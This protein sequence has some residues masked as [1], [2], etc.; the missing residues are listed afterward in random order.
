MLNAQENEDFIAC[1]LG[2]SDSL[3]DS[4]SW[5]P[6]ASDSGISEDPNSDQLDSPPHYVP[7]GSPGAY[8]DGGHSELA[9]TSYQDPCQAMSVL[10]ALPTDAREAEVSIDFSECTIYSI[11]SLLIAALA[12]FSIWFVDICRWMNQ[13]LK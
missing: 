10:K 8:S 13:I 6:A 9:Y 4:P 2:P 3:L 5:S 7:T 11:N 1:I 12:Q